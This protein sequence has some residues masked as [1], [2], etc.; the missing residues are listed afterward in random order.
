M[1]RRTSLTVSQRSSD[2][3]VPV[4]EAWRRVAAATPGSRWY[5]DAPPFVLR[6]AIDRALGG[7]GRRWPLPG[8]PLLETGDVAG[9]WRV[10]EA[11]HE[12][13]RLVLEAAVRAPG[14]VRMTTT[15]TAGGRGTGCTLAQEIAFE[16][17]GA[18]GAAYLWADL[19]AREAVLEVAHRRAAAE[20]T[21]T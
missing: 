14:R 1:R 12:Q 16:P 18:L 3:A 10:V 11:D 17:S 5:V 6:G 13:H 20:A 4:T 15:V 21:A 2:L 8:R 9:F 19:P 7:A